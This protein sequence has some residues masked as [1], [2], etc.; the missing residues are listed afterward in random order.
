M[1]EHVDE[2]LFIEEKALVDTMFKESQKTVLLNQVG[3]LE[4]KNDE[5]WYIGSQ[6]T[7]VEK[8]FL[9]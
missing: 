9:H 6:I 1:I 2:L 8:R 3:I 4:K 5:I 7:R